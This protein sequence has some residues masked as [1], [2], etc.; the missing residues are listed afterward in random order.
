VWRAAVNAFR[1]GDYARAT[2]L[3]ERLLAHAPQ[4]GDYRILA[5]RTLCELERWPEAEQHAR[6]LL[7][8]STGIDDQH[9]SAPRVE[10]WQQ[11]WAR[12]VQARVYQHTG[13]EEAACR[14][15]HALLDEAGTSSHA[16]AAAQK[17]LTAFR[18]SNNQ[19]HRRDTPRSDEPADAP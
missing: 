4:K 3:V 9:A 8:Q 7:E 19:P 10:T 17:L 12:V 15:L 11:D 1:S 5:A 16:R 14:E 6:W 18:A 2:P 13:R